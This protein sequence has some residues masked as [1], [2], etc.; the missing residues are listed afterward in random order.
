MI[1]V[2]DERC[3]YR[4]VR[5]Q[6]IPR[7]KRNGIYLVPRYF[8]LRE[9]RDQFLKSR[10]EYWASGKYNARDMSPYRFVVDLLLGI[11]VI[12]VNLMG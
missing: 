9:E 6:L 8:K 4:I 1:P 5:D 3:A 12:V 7:C 2:G 11:F 10:Q